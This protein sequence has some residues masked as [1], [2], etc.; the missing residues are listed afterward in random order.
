MQL[1]PTLAQFDVR[2]RDVITG[3]SPAGRF[4]QLDDARLFDGELHAALAAEG[5]WGL[6][7]PRELGGSG[8]S[9]ADQLVVLRALGHHATSMGMFGVVSFLCTRILAAN[10]TAT[11]REEYL[12]PL[13]WA[14]CNPPSA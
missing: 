2:L 10:A 11:Q 7:I 8:G 4:Q 1:P 3:V 12:R 6:G 13:R 5:V 14:G 9:T